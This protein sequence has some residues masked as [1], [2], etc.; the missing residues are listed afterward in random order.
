MNMIWFGPHAYDDAHVFCGNKSLDTVNATFRSSSCL[1]MQLGLRLT[2]SQH[3]HR[4]EDT[5]ADA[6]WGPLRFHFAFLLL[7]LR[8]PGSVCVWRS[9]CQLYVILFWYFC[10]VPVMNFNVFPWDF[11]QKHRSTKWH[12][13]FELEGKGF[14]AIP[15]CY[16][17]KTPISMV[18]DSK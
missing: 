3:R 2:T 14:I 15:R 5:D 17:C 6:G 7:S 18:F 4:S 9:T 13:I 11:M 16:K 1:I 10:L 8:F 12:V